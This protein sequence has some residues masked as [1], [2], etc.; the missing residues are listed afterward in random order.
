[1]S[2]VTEQSVRFQTAL[3]SIKLI[4]ASAVLDLTEDDFDFLTS[5]K[6]WIATDRSRA[7]RCVEACV[8][9][10]LDF[11]GY[12]RFPAP[13]EFIAAVIA[14][15]VHPVN[16][17]TACLIMEGAEFTENIINGVERP[18]YFDFERIEAL[19]PAIE[20]CGISTLSQSPMLGFHKQ[21]DNRIKL[22]EEILSFRMQGVEFDNGDM[23]VDGHKAASDVRDE[24]VS[25]TEKL[26]DE[27]AQC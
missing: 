27:L 26:M 21:M 13:V 24:F 15:Y 3:A 5:N 16:I 2:Q 14:Y 6:V 25:V 17:Q 19:K 9:G 7:R 12:P 10:T 22:L 18:D 11:V 4:Q 8:Y 23:Y 1:M 20:A